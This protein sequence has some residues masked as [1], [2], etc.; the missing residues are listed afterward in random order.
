MENLHEISVIIPIYNAEKYLNTCIE[1]LLRQTFK[2]IEIILVDDGSPDR[3]S[4]ICD[5]YASRFSNIR[6]IHRKN[7]GAGYARNSGLDIASGRYV[8]FL[9]P[10]DFLAPNTLECCRQ[11]AEKEEADQVRYMFHRFSDDSKIDILPVP[12]DKPYVVASGPDAIQPILAEIAPLLDKVKVVAPTTASGSTALYRHSVIKKHGI[13]FLSE[14]EWH[15]EDVLFTIDFALVCRKIVYT[16]YP[17]YYYR[18]NPSSL[19]QTLR[20]DYID[21]ASRFSKFLGDKLEKKG[22]RDAGIYAMGYAIAEMRWANRLI[23]FSDMS[24]AEKKK[25]FNEIIEN[26]YIKQIMD[27]YPVARLPFMKK[28]AFNLHVQRQFL[29]SYLITFLRDSLN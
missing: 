19:S 1:S 12:T 3:C 24:L 8:V 26:E 9:D 5:D 13:R 15:S 20:P 18:R 25:L 22:I 23:F 29:A 11:L 21:R 10:D 27:S 7:G 6:V 14:R 28:V 17:F 2:D 4:E 16:P